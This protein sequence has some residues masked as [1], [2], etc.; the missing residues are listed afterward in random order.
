[1]KVGGACPGSSSE[2][3]KG[4]QFSHEKNPPT[5]VPPRAIGLQIPVRPGGRQAGCCQA[6]ARSAIAPGPV[7]D[8]RRKP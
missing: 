1:M 3:T 8:M 5:A 4:L 6:Q 2:Q 7:S